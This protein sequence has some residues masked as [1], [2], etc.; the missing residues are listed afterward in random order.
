MASRFP[1]AQRAVSRQPYESASPSVS[2]V[3]E[4]IEN[5]CNAS[6]VMGRRKGELSKARLDR[7][8]PH[9]VMLPANRCSGE[10][11]PLMHAFC[12]HLSLAPRHHSLVRNDEW[13][14]VF[15]FAVKEHAEIFR[16]RFSGEHF[17][18]ATRGRGRDWARS[19][20]RRPKTYGRG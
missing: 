6:Q 14:L 5:K 7:E 17:D 8:W 10:W 18:P 1:Q 3:I 13:H 11:Y 20:V 9:Q 16:E 2:T 4:Q 19:R 15:C 12:L